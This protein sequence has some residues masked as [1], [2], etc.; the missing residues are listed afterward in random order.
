MVGDVVGESTRVL[1]DVVGEST[2]VLGDIVAM[3]RRDARSTADI[4]CDV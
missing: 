3:H 2:R 1:G 4:G